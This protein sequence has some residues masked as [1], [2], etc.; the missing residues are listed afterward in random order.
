MVGV[1]LSAGGSTH[2]V[3]NE[4]DSKVVRFDTATGQETRNDTLSAFAP[5]GAALS[6]DGTSYALA[7]R[8]KP[9]S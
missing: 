6:S 7:K 4:T 3:T 8:G 2:F 5:L 9:L 1:A